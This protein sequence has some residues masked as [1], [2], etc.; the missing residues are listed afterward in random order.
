MGADHEKNFLT[1]LNFSAGEFGQV[2]SKILPSKASTNVKHNSCFTIFSLK[3]QTHGGWPWKVT[4]P[5]FLT[6]LHTSG[7]YPKKLAF[8]FTITVRGFI[9]VTSKVML[10]CGQLKEESLFSW[11]TAKVVQQ[12]KAQR[13]L[14]LV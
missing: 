1:V 2:I 6:V 12:S 13:G 8:A 5:N 4:I 3:S 14:F 10:A 11:N 9:Y 7:T